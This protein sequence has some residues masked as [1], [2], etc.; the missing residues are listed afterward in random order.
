M[1]RD[2]KIENILIDK[3]GIAKLID[4]GLANLFS[5]YSHLSTFCGSLYFAAPELLSAKKYIGPEVDMWSLGVILYVL[6]CGK[7]PFDDATMPELHARIK[8]GDYTPPTHVS[9]DCIH[10]ISRL[11]VVDPKKRAS[12]EEVRT[13]PWIMR[14]YD[15]APENFVPARSPITL[16][17]DSHVLKRMKGFGLG[18]ESDIKRMIE[19]YIKEGRHQGSQKWLVGG[20]AMMCPESPIMSLY[21]LVLEKYQRKMRK[22]SKN[23]RTSAYSIESDKLKSGQE[24]SSLSTSP[25]KSNNAWKFF[26]RK[27]NNPQEHAYTPDSSPE[28]AVPDKSSFIDSDLAKVPSPKKSKTSIFKT[29]VTTM[30]HQRMKTDDTLKSDTS[31]FVSGDP[32]FIPHDRVESLPTEFMSLDRQQ[33]TRA[34]RKS[35]TREVIQS[36]EDAQLAQEKEL[37]QI[38]S[39]FINGSCTSMT[40]RQMKTGF[41]ATLQRTS[42]GRKRSKTAA[43]LTTRPTAEANNIKKGASQLF[44]PSMAALRSISSRIRITRK[45]R[46]PSDDIPGAAATD[47]RTA[48]MSSIFTIRNTTTLPPAAIRT[49]LL[50]AFARVPNL[51]AI[52]QQGGFFCKYYDT[53]GRPKAVDVDK[54]G[55]FASMWAILGMPPAADSEK[56]LPPVPVAAEETAANLFEH[57]H[58]SQNTKPKVQFEVCIRK[59][60][61]SEL[62]GIQFNKISGDPWKV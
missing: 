61:W 25:L 34:L 19:N 22:S 47:I 60:P 50:R 39:T 7:V 41:M 21:Y 29:K 46:D 13:H 26:G 54:T 40:D 9:K 28:R 10:L 27:S 57:H 20:R 43:D 15:A 24:P 44:S 58:V 18:S 11:L 35:K 51:L 6:V 3:N 55:M 4:F 36:H 52:E 37:P 38:P 42:F 16:P 5:P 14:F 49:E 23:G 12:M 1:H 62:H 48:Y 17:L 33:S 59:I 2:L 32:H 8:L 31:V 53:Q 45:E 56:D 30:L